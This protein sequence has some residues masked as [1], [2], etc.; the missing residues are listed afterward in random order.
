MPE[1]TE[2]TNVVY[3]TN[4]NKGTV[5]GYLARE[6]VATNLVV[7]A[8]TNFMPVFFTNVVQVP[9]TNLVA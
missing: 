6:P 8:V 9:V 4:A 5:S 7:I 2:R 1:V 3:V